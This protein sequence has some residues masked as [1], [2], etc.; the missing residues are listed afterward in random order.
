MISSTKATFVFVLGDKVISGVGYANRV[1]LKM[2]R[3]Y[4][5]EQSIY[6]PHRVVMHTSKFFDLE[7][8]IRGHELTMSE[9]ERVSRKLVSDCSIEELIFA[10]QKK[11]KEK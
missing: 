9:G 7:V 8:S 1:T 5:E 3:D 2:D 6:S 4:I 11:A 10:I